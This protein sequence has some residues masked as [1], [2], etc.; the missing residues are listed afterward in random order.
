MEGKR[1]MPYMNIVFQWC[2]RQPLYMP[3]GGLVISVL[4]LLSLDANLPYYRTGLAVDACGA[5]ISGIWT[6]IKATGHGKGFDR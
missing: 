4:A 5:I 1:T 2:H 6:L 3:L